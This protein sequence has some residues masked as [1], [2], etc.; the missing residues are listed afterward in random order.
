M[1]ERLTNTLVG[2]FM[3]AAIIALLVLAF[4]VSGLTT[5][6]PAKSYEVKADFDNIGDLKV[7]APVSVAG[8]KVGQVKAIELNKNT[9]KAVV[10][11]VINE[12]NHIPSDS[13][14][15]IL[16]AGLLGA[17]F[18]SITPGFDEKYLSHGEQITDTHPALQLEAMIGQLLFNMNKQSNS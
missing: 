7:R 11:M 4:R 12:K 8:V 5:Y 17:N 9:Y 14:A 15:S 2:L 18:V 16:T 10:T 1:S 13:S 6:S 3:I